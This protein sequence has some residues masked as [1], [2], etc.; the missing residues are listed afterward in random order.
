M[1]PDSKGIVGNFQFFINQDVKEVDWWIVVDGLPKKES[2]ICPK[3][4]IDCTMF[5]KN[6]GIIMI[7]FWLILRRR[8]GF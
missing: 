4:N 2:V 6:F 3:E 1:T 8:L 5:W 7:I